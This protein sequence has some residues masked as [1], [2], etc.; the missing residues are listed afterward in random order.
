MTVTITSATND[1]IAAVDAVVEEWLFRCAMSRWP[2]SGDFVPGDFDTAAREAAREGRIFVVAELKA[3]L[4]ID[5]DMQRTNPLQILREATRYPTAIL[6]RYGVPSVARDEMDSRIMPNDVYGLSPAHWNDV[7][8]SLM[9][10]GIIWGAAK[11]STML[12]RRRSE[13]KLTE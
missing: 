9:E 8:G 12:Q 13:G 5:V 3:G 6:A 1:L 2:V 11:A 7:H 10:P 4:L